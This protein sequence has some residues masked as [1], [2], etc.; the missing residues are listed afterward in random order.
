[1]YWLDKNRNFTF[2]NNKFESKS[3]KILLE[4]VNRNLRIPITLKLFKRNIQYY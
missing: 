1:M 3:N 4:E 2:T